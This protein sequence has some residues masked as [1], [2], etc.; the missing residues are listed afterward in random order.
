MIDIF[1]NKNL[2]IYKN[3]FKKLLINIKLIFLKK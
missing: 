2:K 1:I 3:K